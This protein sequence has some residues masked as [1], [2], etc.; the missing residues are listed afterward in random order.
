M[1]PKD[2]IERYLGPKL[3]ALIA[4]LAVYGVQ[5]PDLDQLLDKVAQYTNGSPDLIIPSILAA[6]IAYFFRSAKPVKPVKRRID[7]TLFDDS[8]YEAPDLAPVKPVVRPVAP[9]TP[10]ID[11]QRLRAELK[12]DEGYRDR[13]YL[14][15]T[16]HKTAGI[17]HMLTPDDPEYMQDV[18]TI[19][20]SLR[21]DEWFNNDISQAISDAKEV[22]QDFDRHPQA[23]KH[24]LV[25]MAFNLGKSRLSGFT[26]TLRLINAGHYSEAATEALNSK[27]ADQVGKRALRVSAMIASGEPDYNLA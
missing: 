19:V 25:N 8:D 10:G 5:L 24:A 21:I 17:G 3:S 2:L 13:I 20:S 27:W 1:T 4:G 18:G 16:N 22:V 11:V 9:R 12:A 7:E 6:V 14:D 23:V 26:N 15:T